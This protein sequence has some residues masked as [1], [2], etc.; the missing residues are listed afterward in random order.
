[1]D[2]VS[3]ECVSV[4]PSGL[5]V[6]VIALWTTALA[7]PATSRSV[8]AEEYVNVATVSAL[9]PNS[10]VLPVRLALPAPECVLNTS[11]CEIQ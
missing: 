4:T 6:P 1:M 5:E 9:T 10:R 2:A 3:V 8:M 7:W 11:K